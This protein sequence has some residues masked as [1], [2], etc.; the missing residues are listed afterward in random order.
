LHLDCVTLYVAW[1]WSGDFVLLLRFFL[2]GSPARYKERTTGQL[3]P[4]WNPSCARP[5]LVF[6]CQIFYCLNPRSGCDFCSP[7]LLQ[8]PE[9]SPSPVTSLIPALI[10]LPLSVQASASFWICA[11]D[12]R[13]STRSRSLCASVWN[14]SLC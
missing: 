1:V 14:L 11:S 8:S 5:E 2:A 7:I 3:F 4:A 9:I 12:S 10:F 6:R 13:F